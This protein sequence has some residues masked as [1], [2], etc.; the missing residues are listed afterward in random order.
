MKK[1]V[2][3]EPYISRKIQLVAQINAKT[4]VATQTW[5]FIHGVVCLIWQ[6]RF[7]IDEAFSKWEEK[8]F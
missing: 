7:S 3:H 8:A 4:T 5:E 1:R 6:E 2:L